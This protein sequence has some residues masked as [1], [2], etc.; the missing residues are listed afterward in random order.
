MA[1]IIYITGGARSGKSGYAQKR[2]EQHNGTLLYVAT[3]E[4]RDDEMAARVEKHQADRGERWQSLE[5]PVALADKIPKAADGCS[6]VLIDCL[7]LWLSN[8]FE[9]YGEDDDA[10][11]HSATE[12]IA[13]L[14]QLDAAI[15]VVSNEV[16]SG[17]VPE[18]RLARR[19]RDL[20]G[21]INQT[22]A[23]AADEAWLVASGLPLKLK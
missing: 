15:Y 16:G 3:A 1:R 23:T 8:L 4:V 17:I 20:A 7:T 21:Q 12:L 18:N 2:A 13:K 22:F 9:Q 5:E 19:F 11:E 10:I 6:A 14:R